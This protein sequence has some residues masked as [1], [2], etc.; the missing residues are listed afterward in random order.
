MYEDRAVG[1]GPEVTVS[2]KGCRL[3]FMQGT[4]CRKPEQDP[5]QSAYSIASQASYAHGLPPAV[6]FGLPSGCLDVVI[7]GDSVAPG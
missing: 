4:E 3:C 7:L 5:G 6:A 1:E 2:S